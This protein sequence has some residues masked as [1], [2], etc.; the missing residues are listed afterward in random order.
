M[1]GQCW[2]IHFH[3]LIHFSFTPPAAGPRVLALTRFRPPLVD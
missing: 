3:S 1:Y 2:N